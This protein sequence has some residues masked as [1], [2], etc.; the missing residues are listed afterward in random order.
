MPVTTGVVPAQVYVTLRPETC[1]NRPVPPANAGSQAGWN[2]LRNACSSWAPVRVRITV[3]FPKGTTENVSPQV[4][5]Q[6]PS[7]AVG[8]TQRRSARRPP[9]GARL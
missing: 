1:G 7:P 9:D 2:P 5:S 8:G 4:I 6:G 3:R